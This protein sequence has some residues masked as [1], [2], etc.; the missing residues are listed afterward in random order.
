MFLPKSFAVCWAPGWDVRVFG[1]YVGGGS[2]VWGYVGVGCLVLCA[3]EK[4]WRI[5]VHVV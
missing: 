2:C 4:L 3:A 1:V 5:M